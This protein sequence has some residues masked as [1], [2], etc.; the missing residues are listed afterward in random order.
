MVLKL[1]TLSDVT[2]QVAWQ[3][4]FEGQSIAFSDAAQARIEDAREAF[5]RLLATDGGGYV[6][7]ATVAPGARA[8][9]RL[10]DA[11][12]ERMALS[13][14][15]WAPKA[16]GS[17]TA[18][19]PEHAMRLILLSR[20]A[21]FLE[22]YGKVR[23]ETAR[24]VASLLSK[25]VAPMPLE[26]ATGPGEVMP[27]SWLY[28]EGI[29][30]DL[31]AGEIMSLFNGAPCAAGLVTDAA[32][33][34]RRRLDMVLRICALAIETVG[35]PLSAYDPD[36]VN[37]TQ[38][39]HHQ[40]VLRALNATLAGVPTTDRLP[41]QAPVSWRIIPAVLATFRK[42]VND[43]EEVAQHSLRSVAHNP[44]YLPPD[45]EH[46]NGRAVSTGGFHNHQASRA[47]DMLNAA[48]ADICVL[49]AKQTAR[50]MDGTPFGL[51]PLLVPEGSGVIGTEM[52]A[53][54][55]TGPVERARGAAMPAIL[56]AGLEDPGGGQSDIA[57]PVFLA[58]ERYMQGAEAMETA[59]AA[60]LTAIVQASR[61]SGRAPP[62]ELAGFHAAIEAH[63]LP[64]EMDRIAELGQ[65]LRGVKSALSDAAIGTG[66]LAEHI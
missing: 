45:P 53:W 8:K 64:L 16:F 32:L 44:T 10:S 40:H 6:Y 42:A 33:A 66:A 20:I 60:L 9:V 7:G 11:Q 63:V 34:S 31:A 37:L 55:T 48:G 65:S 4:G 2:L 30:V 26:T 13:Q 46:P 38:D 62:P 27:L 18:L 24:W 29:G 50:L 39:P 1:E 3:V 61:L 58:Y 35:A 23:L 54:S 21:S 12:R 57:A 5:E 43:A 49:A 14:S 51:P 15:V 25:P 17:G 22:G 59:L 56:P 36:L 47:I 52:L 41:H 19:V 28:P